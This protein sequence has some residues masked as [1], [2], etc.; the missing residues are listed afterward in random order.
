DY[1][2][3]SGPSPLRDQGDHILP[4]V[5]AQVLPDGSTA[6]T[7]YRRN[8]WFQP[9]SIV[10]TYTRTDGTTG[11]RTNAFVYNDVDL[12]QE[13]GPNAEQVVSNYFG[14]SY[15]QPDASYDALNQETKFTFNS[16]RQLTSVRRPSGLTI[17]NL[18]FTSGEASNRLDR[19]IDWEINRT[20]SY[21]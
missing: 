10:S 13:I 14:N 12:V 2:N 9:S 21:S 17:T 3:K 16:L 6:Y 11:T 18:Y 5:I 7:W 20:N 15:H 4:A 19:T 1:D 8:G